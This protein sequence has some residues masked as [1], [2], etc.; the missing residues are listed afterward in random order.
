MTDHSFR[1]TFMQKVGQIGEAIENVYE[2]A[3]QDIE[4]AY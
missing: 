2:G 4:G 3:P 1:D